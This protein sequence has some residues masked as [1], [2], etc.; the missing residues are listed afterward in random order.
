MDAAKYEAVIGSLEDILVDH[1]EFAMAHADLAVLYYNN[2]NLEKARMHYEKT[3]ALEP[4]NPEYLR[5]L[6][7]FYHLGLGEIESALKIYLKVLEIYPKDTEVLISL[8]NICKALENIEDARFFFN[9]V[10]KIEPWNK[11][12]RQNLEKLET[13]RPNEYRKPADQMYLDN[14][15]LMDAGRY[16]EVIEALSALLDIYPDY[17]MAHTDLGVLHY[18]EGNLEKARM[19]YEKA[20]QLE[21]DNMSFQKNLATFYYQGMGRLEDALQIFLRMMEINPKDIETLINLGNICQISQNSEDAYFFY[22]QVL[23]ID[24]SNKSALNYLQGLNSGGQLAVN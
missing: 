11:Q 6:A 13:T 5:N 22:N 23:A 15:P 19:H 4:I 7:A 18:N 14:K 8:G 10:L 2:G 21:P 17:A 9:Q 24:P 12:V 16:E 1:P 3:V 20:A